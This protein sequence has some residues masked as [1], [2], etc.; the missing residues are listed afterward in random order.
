LVLAA[1]ARRF[2]Q[3]QLSLATQSS[4][5]TA[6]VNR[7]PVRGGVA[8]AAL[9]SRAREDYG[10]M[11]RMRLLVISKEGGSQDTWSNAG[12]IIELGAL[13]SLG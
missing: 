7:A 5:G 11:W 12:K 6:P 1:Q 8:A 9:V 10:S 3:R 13:P 2:G 4:K